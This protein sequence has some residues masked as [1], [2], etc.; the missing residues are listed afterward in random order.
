M[1]PGLGLSFGLSRHEGDKC[2]VT[3]RGIVCLLKH[4]TAAVLWDNPDGHRAQMGAYESWGQSMLCWRNLVT[5]S[6]S[7]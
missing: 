5:E 2:P 1:G 3:W 7:A 4:W 6:V